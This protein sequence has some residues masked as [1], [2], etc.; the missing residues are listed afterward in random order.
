MPLALIPQATQRTGDDLFDHT[1][2]FSF[3]IRLEER[4]IFQTHG[5][6]EARDIFPRL[7]HSAIAQNI[8]EWLDRDER[9]YKGAVH[10]DRGLPQRLEG[11]CTGDFRL[12]DDGNSGCPNTHAGCELAGAHAERLPN[13]LDPAFG[14]GTELHGPQ[15]GQAPFQLFSGKSSLLCVHI[16][17]F[18]Q[19]I[20]YHTYMNERNGYDQVFMPL[21]SCGQRWP[22]P[23]SFTF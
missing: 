22:R 19:S 1:P 3:E 7:L 23:S 8:V 2:P 21:S 9:V 20:N 12:F 6:V 18:F 17:M 10:R 11:G 16:Y 14:R 15:R 4:L 13:G 5:V